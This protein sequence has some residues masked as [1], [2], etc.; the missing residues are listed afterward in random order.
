MK[1]LIQCP[2]CKVTYRV[3][4]KEIVKNN[5]QCMDCRSIY[6][7]KKA[8]IARTDDNILNMIERSK[9]E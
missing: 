5:T 4:D 1:N 9:G 3:S 8:I 2:K 7:Q 6:V